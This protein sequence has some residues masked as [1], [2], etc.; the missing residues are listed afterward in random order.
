MH[1]LKLFKLIRAGHNDRMDERVYGKPNRRAYYIL[2]RRLRDSI[3][4]FLGGDGF[5]HDQQQ[6]MQLLKRLLA[7][8]KLMKRGLYE[9]ASKTLTKYG[10]QARKEELYSIYQ[11]YLTTRLEYHHK[12]KNEVE[13]DALAD[14]YQQNQQQLQLADR[15]NLFFAQVNSKS[16]S[17]S[18]AEIL[19]E[20]RPARNQ[21]FT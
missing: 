5:I 1:N 4:E 15:L 16:R 19:Q 14:K 6:E 8:R 10:E 13:I 3:V 7:A 18:P 9:L 11:E 2:A 17:H 21:H 20:L 12:C